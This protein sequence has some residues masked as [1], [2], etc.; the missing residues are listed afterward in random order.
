MAPTKQKGGRGR[1]VLAALVLLSLAGGGTLAA[2]RF[3]AVPAPTTGTVVVTTNPPGAEVVLDGE[4]RGV[5][6][7]TLTV[8]AGTHVLELR[9]SGE[10]RLISLEVAAGAHLAQYIELGQG[11][12]PVTSV[13]G[14]LQVRTEPAG[15]GI[16]VDGVPRGVS[17]V[18]VADLPPGE[19]TVVAE[20]DAGA[21]TQTV[22]VE[23][24]ATASLVAPLPV[25]SAPASGW[26]SVTTPKSVQLFED[27]RLLGTSDTERLMV[28][29]GTHE[30]DLVNDAIGYRETRT[31]QVTGGK[32][33]TIDV[34][35]PNGTI[36][37]NAAPWADVWIDGENVGE[38][39]I[40]NLPVAAGP[41]EVI[42]RHPEFGEQRHMI[43][44]TL[45]A[46]AR[47]SVDMRKKP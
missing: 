11:Q 33:S 41:H 44:V 21:T 37:L 42:F 3:L 23:A 34:E 12:G 6:P 25:P 9:S 45:A 13:S 18:T 43:T 5:S 19:H 22:T 29:A 7:T 14:S 20:T 46:P 39:P 38:T 40:G 36:A 17:P 16:S 28:P 10:P 27:G 8:A 26:I 15:A 30:L 24:G 2:R 31:V 1:L 35:F 32:V 4:P 47:L